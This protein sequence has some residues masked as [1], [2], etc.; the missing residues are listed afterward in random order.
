MSSD[1]QVKATVRYIKKAYDRM[2]FKFRKEENMPEIMKS[3]CEKYNYRD[4]KGNVNRSDFIK[5]AIETQMK[6]DRGDC[7]IIE[8]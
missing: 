5:Q 1:A 2:E 8:K 4:E 3:H 7:T 6:I